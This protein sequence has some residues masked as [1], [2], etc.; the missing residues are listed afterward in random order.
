MSILF[1]DDFVSVQFEHPRDDTESCREV[2][3]EHESDVWK[4]EKEKY[5]HKILRSKKLEAPKGA[6]ENLRS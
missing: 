6:W 4:D 1:L 2:F 3:G 5:Q